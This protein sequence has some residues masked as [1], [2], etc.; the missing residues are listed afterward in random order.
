M[1]GA[2]I[3]ANRETYR[4]PVEDPPEV[5][6]ET[7]SKAHGLPSRQ[8]WIGRDEDDALYAF[9]SQPTWTGSDFVPRDGERAVRLPEEW[10]PEIEAGFCQA[11]VKQGPRVDKR[12]KPNAAAT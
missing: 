12:V 4:G 3:G 9:P 2:T 5:K 10:F 8:I 7:E 1:R 6:P 11:F